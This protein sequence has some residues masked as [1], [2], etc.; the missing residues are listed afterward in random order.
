MGE[1]EVEYYLKNGKKLPEVSVSEKYNV[2]LEHFE[3][4]LKEKGEYTA[5]REIR[6]HISWYVKGMKN[7]T[8]I[9]NEINSVESEADFKKILKEYF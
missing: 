1:L 8:T 9:R 5:T 7:A 3:L 6:K 4:L 2:I